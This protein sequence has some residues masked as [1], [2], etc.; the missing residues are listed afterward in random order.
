MSTCMFNVV[1]NDNEAPTVGNCNDFSVDSGHQRAI[2]FV[3][4]DR[5]A[6]LM[7]ADNCGL[8][9][10]HGITINPFLSCDDLGP[11]NVTFGIKDI[12]GNETPC[13]WWF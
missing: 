10:N 8:A 2:Y 12:N 5:H 6:Q 9:A 3:Q 7:T 13:T 11:N 4:W 1:V